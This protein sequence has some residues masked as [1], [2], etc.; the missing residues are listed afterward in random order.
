METAMQASESSINSRP[1]QSR[2]IWKSIPGYAIALACLLWVFHD[3]QFK[4]LVQSM[5]SIQWWWVLGAVILDTASY[6]CQGMRWSLLLHP[7]GRIS[8][9]EA[10]QAVYAGLY[11]NELLPMRLGEILRLYLA[12]RKA[13]VQFSAVVPSVLVERFFDSVW[14]ALT[15]GITV[16]A[17]PLPKYLVESEEILG[18]AALGATALFIYLVLSKR[19][20]GPAGPDGRK[21]HRIP[22]RW[23]SGFLEKMAGGIRDIGRSRYFYSSFGISLLLLLGQIL[24]YWFGMGLRCF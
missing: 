10:T 19:K 20:P 8:T 16:L 13:Q 18:F 2:N 6:V 12:S 23:I 3:V 21:R 14:L 17:I 4:E 9:V 1:S 7:V 11:V 22:I 5:K 15:F 24:A